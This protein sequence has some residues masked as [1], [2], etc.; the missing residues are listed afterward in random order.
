MNSDARRDVRRERDALLSHENIEILPHIQEE[1]TQADPAAS[2]V[3][4][5][6]F[7]SDELQKVIEEAGHAIGL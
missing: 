1:I 3:F 5:A 4:V 7:Q 6:C 2:E